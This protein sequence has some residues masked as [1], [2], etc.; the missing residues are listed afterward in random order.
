MAAQAGRKACRRPPTRAGGPSARGRQSKAT[1]A[2][3]PPGDDRAA[4]GVSL[5]GIARGLRGS[6]GWA[7]GLAARR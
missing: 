6:L 2:L 3:G 4:R 1:A 5:S 7:A